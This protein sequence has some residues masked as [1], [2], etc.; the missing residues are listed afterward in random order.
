VSD[1]KQCGWVE[2]NAVLYV[3]GELPDDQRH[4]LENHV[5]GCGE[6]RRAIEQERGLQAAMDLEPVIEPSASL[7]ASARMRLEA[8]LD[9]MPAVGRVGQ[10]RQIL[11]GWG[12]SLRT[13]PTMAGLLLMVG[14]GGG[15]LM[16]WQA[17]KHEDNAKVL[18]KTQSAG[19][20]VASTGLP[21]GIA[22]IS[23]IVAEPGTN[24]VEVKYN[25]LVPETTEGTLEN[26]AIRQLVLL[27]TQNRLNPGVRVDSVG[28]L[29]GECH[30]ANQCED[31]Q[32]RE[33]LMAALRYDKN[34]GV[35]LK[36]LEGLAP[37][38]AQDEAVRNTVLNAVL[39]DE[40]PGVRTQAIQMLTPLESDGSVRDVLHTVANDDRNPYIR[41]VS[42]EALATAPEMQ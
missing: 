36:A 21:E 15:G 7:V 32:V 3:Y 28:L 34:A 6:C 39:H 1:E 27:A 40:C 33:A 35:R 14:F 9:E 18:E 19:V 4:R 13:A 20:T 2:E 12:F 42:Q 16:G 22:S 10:L 24:V 17:H 26:P 30:A 8:A 23:G 41:N 25:R 29:A 5:R 11:S 31:A 38:V 37:M